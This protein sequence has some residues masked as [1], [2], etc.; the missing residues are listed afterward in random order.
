MLEKIKTLFRDK[1][2]IELFQK[3]GI[4]LF[5]RVLSQVMGFVFTLMI[6]KYFGAKGLGDYVLAIIVL[7]VF[8]LLAKLGIDVASIR[9]IAGFAIKNRWSAIKLYRK[10]ILSLL[11]CT[12][13]IA[14]FVMYFFAEYIAKAVGAKPEYIMLNSFFVLPMVLFMLNY[15]SMRGLKKIKEFSFF[16]WLSRILFSVIILAV[17]VQFTRN[18]NIPILSFLLSLVVVFVLSYIV[19]NQIFNQIKKSNSIANDLGD[20]IQLKAILF[21]SLPLLFAQSSQFLMSW[22]DRLMLGGMTSSYEVG[23]YDVAF[24]LSMFV[25]IALTAVTSISSPKFAELYEKKDFNRL[26][27]VVHQSTKLIFWSSIPL[28]VLFTVV[29]IFILDLFG[30]DFYNGIYALV[31][32]CTARLFSV[33]TG[34]AGNLLQMTG[35]QLTYMNVLF[36]GAAIN[37]VLNYVFIQPENPFS[38][39]GIHGI[40]GAAFA[41]FIS[42]IFWNLTM[43]YYVKRKFGFFTIYFPFLKK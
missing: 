36:L 20:K 5:M 3:G 42:I 12:S 41:S 26:E 29:S 1:D 23:I 37:I 35:N 4:S 31:I 17:A 11:I 22:T 14:S 27:K 6:A 39:L 13:L 33:F 7:R 25:N 9:Y 32:L 28:L 40:N 38:H 15:Q 8:S 24:K 43:V 21:V 16:Y 10:K 18:V 30:D 2:F 34:P 19:Y